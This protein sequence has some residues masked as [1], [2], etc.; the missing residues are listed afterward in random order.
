[1]PPWLQIGVT[2]L[3][4]TV[5]ALLVYRLVSDQARIVRSKALIKAYLL[6]L[7]LYK[8][9]PRVLL[10]AQVRV[11][12]QSLLYLKSALLPLALLL[13]PVGLLTA[14]IEARFAWQAPSPGA[15]LLVVA[16]VGDEAALLRRAPTLEGRG[17]RVE[18]EALRVATRG[19]CCGG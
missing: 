10:A 1:M 6:E 18:T 3:P 7:W 13:L 5:L 2:A 12:W 17:V 8:D 4:L 14:Q 9:D 16:T 15:S 11:V 19:K